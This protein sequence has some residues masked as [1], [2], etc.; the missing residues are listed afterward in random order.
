MGFSG[1]RRTADTVWH[2]LPW[3]SVPATSFLQPIVCYPNTELIGSLPC[4]VSIGCLLERIQTL[5]NTRGQASQPQLHLGP[6]RNLGLLHAAFPLVPW[7]PWAFQYLLAFAHAVY[8]RNALLPPLPLALS[9]SH[10][11]TSKKGKFFVPSS[12]F[13]QYLVLIQ[14]RALIGSS[15]IYLLTCVL[16]P[17][18]P[19]EG[20]NH[21]L[22]ISVSGTS[23]VFKLCLLNGCMNILWHLC[24]HG[25]FCEFWHLLIIFRLYIGRTWE[26]R[27]LG[28]LAAKQILD[29]KCCL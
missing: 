28:T 6:P 10:V 26:A 13:P 22:V 15:R 24:C 8:S 29:L 14:G 17:P 12:V 4:S 23:L 1:P 27:E 7:D 21:W 2:S 5:T 20:R 16:P 9:P 18:Q 25:L 19:V 11:S 3:R